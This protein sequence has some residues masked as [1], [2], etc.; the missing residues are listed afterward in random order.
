MQLRKVIS[1]LFLVEAAAM[2]DNR[3]SAALEAAAEVDAPLRG[4]RLGAAGRVS[5]TDMPFWCDA[6]FCLPKTGWRTTYCSAPHEIKGI[7]CWRGRV[8]GARRL[9]RA[10]L[11]RRDVRHIR[12]LLPKQPGQRQCDA[13]AQPSVEG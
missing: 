3:Q 4:A 5:R 12:V 8:S 9:R 1:L 7:Y 13:D 11:G 2:S 6:S 10:Q